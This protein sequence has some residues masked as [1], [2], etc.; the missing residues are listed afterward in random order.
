[1]LK[2]RGH[3]A[4]LVGVARVD[5]ALEHLLQAH[6]PRLLAQ[7]QDLGEQSTESLKVAA[8][9]LADSVVFWLLI[10]LQH[11]KRHI[12]GKSPLGPVPPHTGLRPGRRDEAMTML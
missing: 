12:L 5:T 10:A 8:A 2:E 6:H 1:M 4:V 3:G 7:P 9:K 11:P